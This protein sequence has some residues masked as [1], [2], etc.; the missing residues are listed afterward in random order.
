MSNF[1][2]VTIS[3]LMKC[4]CLFLQQQQHQQQHQQHPHL[5]VKK[6][7]LKS[8]FAKCKIHSDK[9]VQCAEHLNSPRHH[10]I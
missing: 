1:I 6:R 9:A 10:H 5:S 3:K 7:N 8:H 4:N 2:Y